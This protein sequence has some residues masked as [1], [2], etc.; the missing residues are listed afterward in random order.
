VVDGHGV[1]SE[2]SLIPAQKPLARDSALMKPAHAPAGLESAGAKASHIMTAATEATDAAT[3]EAAA[4]NAAEA[5]ASDAAEATSVEGAASDATPAEA[6][7]ATS[8]EATAA[9]P[10]EA[11]AAPAAMKSGIGGQGHHHGCRCHQQDCADRCSGVFH[12][13]P[14]WRH[15]NV[16][17]LG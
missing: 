17:L 16:T 13:L 8:A 6:T 7:S 3:A 11:A 9:A 15:V 10:V 5:T 12:E 4:A 14:P 1:I 2:G